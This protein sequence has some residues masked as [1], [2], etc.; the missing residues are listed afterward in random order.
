MLYIEGSDVTVLYGH[1]TIA[2]LWGKMAYCVKWKIGE[3]LFPSFWLKVK[4][5]VVHNNAQT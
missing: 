2:V 1:G 4:V 3:V 5:L